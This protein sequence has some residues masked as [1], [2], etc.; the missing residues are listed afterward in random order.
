[1]KRLKNEIQVGSTRCR[2]RDERKQEWEKNE[3]EIRE[4]VEELKEKM[5]REMETFVQTNEDKA[6]LKQWRE[7]IITRIKQQKETQVH[8]LMN[9]CSATF[10]YLQTQQDVEEN[11]QA[12]TEQLLQ[13]AKAFMTSA[14]DTKDPNKCKQAFDQEWKQWISKVPCCLESKID[15]NNEMED[16]LLSTN[17]ILNMEMSERSKQ[18]NSIILYFHDAT[19]DID[20]NQLRINVFS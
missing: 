1:M 8:A 7:Y 20:I 6:V 14:I 18:R 11:K 10:R 19:P 15:I 12:Y 13:K 17:S 16:V 9:T 3:R 4:R 2:T 5:Q